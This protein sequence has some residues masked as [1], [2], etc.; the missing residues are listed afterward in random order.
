MNKHT[1]RRNT[2]KR[3][4]AAPAHTAPA[5]GGKRP[6]AG[7]GGHGAKRRATAPRRDG[8]QGAHASA[9]AHADEVRVGDRIVVTTK[10]IGINGEGVGYYKRKAVFVGGAL[11]GEVVKAKVTAAEHNRL[12]ASLVGIEKRS[13]HRIRPA[14]GVYDACGGCQLQHMS[15]EGQ[16]AA[17]EEL[18]REAFARYAGLD[19]A[20]LPLRPILGMDAP[21]GYRNKAQLQAGQAADGGGLAIGL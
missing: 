20:A 3:A 18:V 14:C 4:S 16:L 19:G 21:W 1:D 10:R 8:S 7:D 2:D 6:V 12:V 15:Y 11:P 5:A 13:P 9:P 17:K